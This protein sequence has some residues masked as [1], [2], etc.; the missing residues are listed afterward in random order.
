MNQKNVAVL[1]DFENVGDSSLDNLFD[2]ISDIEL[3]HC[4][5]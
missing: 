2:T 1:I 5:L 4:Y 3:S